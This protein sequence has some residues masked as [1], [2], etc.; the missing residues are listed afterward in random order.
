VKSR[1]RSLPGPFED[2]NNLVDDWSLATQQLRNDKRVASSMADLRS[3]YDRMT[4]RIKEIAAYLDE[5]PIDALPRSAVDIL[6]LGLM[7]MEIAPAVEVMKTPDVVSDY[8]RGRLII[9]PQQDQFK[10]AAA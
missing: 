4:P 10:V 1:E 7:L 6:F 3:F 5:Y 2:L 8:P 9:H